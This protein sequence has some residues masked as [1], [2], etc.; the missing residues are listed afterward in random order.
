MN[1]RIKPTCGIVEMTNRMDDTVKVVDRQK[2]TIARL[3]ESLSRLGKAL[4]QARRGGEWRK[5]GVR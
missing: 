4:R 2:E 1:S 5:R 3:D